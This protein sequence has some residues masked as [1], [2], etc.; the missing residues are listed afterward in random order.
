MEGQRSDQGAD[1][2]L[3]PV[4]GREVGKATQGAPSSRRRDSNGPGLLEPPMAMSKPSW[5]KVVANGMGTPL[6]S[7]AGAPCSLDA[8][9]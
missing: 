7:T 4:I 8:G 6:S 9:A 2:T 5:R 1:G 3:S